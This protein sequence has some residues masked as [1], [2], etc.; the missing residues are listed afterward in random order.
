MRNFISSPRAAG[1]AEFQITTELEQ[2]EAG[3]IRLSLLQ[4]TR[5]KFG[6]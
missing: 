1:P 2:R 4:E 6:I 3:L 5:K